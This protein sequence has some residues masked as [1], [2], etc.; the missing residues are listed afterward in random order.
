MKKIAIFFTAMALLLT[1]AAALAQNINVAGT[2][3]DEAGEAVVGA[4]VV[5]KGSPSVY[6]M[7]DPSGAFRISVPSNGVLE[8]S[9]LGY[10]KVDVP[11]NGRSTIAVVLQQDAQRLDDV[12]VVAYGTVR[13]EAN[14]GSVVQMKSETLAEAPVTSVDKMLAG[15]MAGVQL[16]SYS[17][18]PGSTTTVRIRGISSINAGNEPLWVVDGI[19]II[20]DDN[21]QISS[22]G[23]GGG[24]NTAFL[25]PNDIESIT[26]LKDAAAASV[27]GSRAANGVILVTTK[28]GKAGQ[29]RFTARV[30]FG[31]QQLFSTID[32]TDQTEDLGDDHIKASDYGISNLKILMSHLE[33]WTSEPGERYDAMENVYLEVIKQYNRYVKHVTPY[34]G[35]IRFE[36]IR[37]GDQ[38]STSKHY[39]P[40]AQQQRAMKWLLQQARTYDDW[41][42]PITLI[43]KFEV[44]R[45]FNTKLREQIVSSMLNA[46]VLFRVKESG[47]AD[48][49]NNYQIDDYL[50]DV[51][52]A[53]FIA[54]QGGKLSDAEQ[55]LQTSA[56]KLFLNGSGLAATKSSSSS[57]LSEM[58]TD[59]CG[60]CGYTT[61][62]VRLNMGVSALTKDQM[63][64]LM[65][66][67]LKTVLQKYKTYRNAATGS[68]R[69]YYDYMILQMEKALT[70]K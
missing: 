3:K 47:A 52:N 49:A 23:V 7:T 32:P 19:P 1:S 44:E 61:D 9:C 30:K 27:Y 37:Q 36:E 51:T 33:E 25:N 43:G 53:I 48:K 66:G 22:N 28:S 67:R 29:A 12:V 4:G 68:T 5:L 24:S 18:Q 35:G 17:G 2:V 45:D 50:R 14:T 8:I 65:T 11:V 59:D 69:D 57:S 46:A 56:I 64:A 20:A 31:A 21:R 34:L 41:L 10:Q 39:I 6:A 15:K 42:A 16:S 26:V 63:G 70:V 40:K 54:P 62:F 58:A 13:R 55:H 38:K 60:F